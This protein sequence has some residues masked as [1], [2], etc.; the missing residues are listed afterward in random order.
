MPSHLDEFVEMIGDP[1]YFGIDFQFPK[2]FYEYYS[3]IFENP[4]NTLLNS[5]FSSNQLNEDP[6]SLSSY[7]ISGINDIVKNLLKNNQPFDSQGVN[8]VVEP[9]SL[10]ILDQQGINGGHSNRFWFTYFTDIQ[11]RLTPIYNRPDM[12]IS[13][14]VTDISIITTDIGPYILPN[15]FFYA[16]E[17]DG[18]D[19]QTYSHLE[20]PREILYPCIFSLIEQIIMHSSYQDIKG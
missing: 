17:F 7:G 4:S 12:E 3:G 20:E 11:Q 6:N 15:K 19:V 13:F 1:N 18:D 16:I 10:M 5:H 9:D 2:E 14:F 8:L